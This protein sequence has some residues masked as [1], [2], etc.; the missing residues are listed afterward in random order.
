MPKKIKTTKSEVI[1]LRDLDKPR[2]TG[3]Q[4]VS[5][6]RGARTSAITSQAKN[7]SIRMATSSD[8]KLKPERFISAFTD[9]DGIYFE[10][11]G[12][13]VINQ[14][15]EDGVR[16]L[17]LGARSRS[18]FTHA[19]PERYVY[20]FGKTSRAAASFA[21][22]A[23]QTWGLEATKVIASKYTGKGVRLAVLDTGI[24]DKHPDFKGRGIVSQSFILGEQVA[25]GNGHGTHCAGV[26]CGHVQTASGAPEPGQRYGVA[27]GAKLYVGKVL[28]NRGSGSDRNILAGI[29]WALENKCR[30][31]SMSLGAAAEVGDAYS[32]IYE[33]LAK[34]LLT[35]NTMIIAAAGNE[36]DRPD[37]IAPIGHPANCP[38]I[39]AV[40]AIDSAL[41]VAYFSCGGTRAKGGTVDVAAPGVDVLSSVPRPQL[42]ELMNGT[43]MATP[44][45]AGIAALMC[46]RYPKAS[47]KQIWNHVIRTARALRLAK[48]DGGSGLVIA[49]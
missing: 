44:L 8:F 13:A 7:A 6:R 20:A 33:D 27:H 14:E 2:F 9:G 1:S 28:S 41:K 38:S 3:S 29:Q 17:T 25:D 46:Q 49:P 16:M 24:D 39:M 18:A 11:L 40:A 35:N 37:R 12:I 26:A 45:V 47:A 43:S 10:K 32:T 5:V 42:Y 36:S 34:E 31:I 19:E 4:L 22:T 23:A 15:R 48:R 30:I 21:D